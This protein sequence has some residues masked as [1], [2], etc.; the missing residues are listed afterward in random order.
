[1]DATY[2]NA[3]NIS[4]ANEKVVHL[5]YF[6]CFQF[7]ASFSSWIL[8]QPPSIPMT[9]DH[10]SSAPATSGCRF[11]HPPFPLS[12]YRR[13]SRR[14]PHMK[15]AA[16]PPILLRRPTMQR[17]LKSK[18]C[19]FCCHSDLRWLSLSACVKMGKEQAVFLPLGFMRN[20]STQPRTHSK[21]YSI[22]FNT[23]CP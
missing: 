1:M 10:I 19:V 12:I 9:P 6:V 8:G 5:F 11:W 4:I 14:Q 2:F 23:F 20:S 7:A 15:T 3:S 13:R 17:K 21:R 18:L 22:S 16:T